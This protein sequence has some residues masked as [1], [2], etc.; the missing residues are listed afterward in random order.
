MK[1]DKVL[2]IGGGI[3]G[4]TTALALQRLGIRAEVFEKSSHLQTHATGFTLWSYAIRHLMD[5]GLSRDTLNSFGSAVQI[6]EIRNK[7]GKLLEEMPV[8]EVSEKLGAP[9]YE[10]LRANL[11]Q[12]IMNSLAPDSLHLKK[13][14]IGVEPAGEKVT[15]IFQ[16]GTQV[17]GDLLI[18]A[19]GIHS[20]V[21]RY[22]A[23][24]FK[25]NYSG[26]SA[27]VAVLPFEHE[28]LAPQHHVEI[29][30]RGA[31]AGVADVGPSQARWYVTHQNP[32]GADAN[33][34][35]TE[36]LE[37]IQGWYPL[38]RDAV[39]ATDA[40]RLVRVEVWDLEPLKT[41][42]KGRV[43][44]LGDAAHATTPFAAMGANM[45]IQDSVKLVDLLQ[46][47]S[48]LDEALQGFQDHRKKRTEEV[49]KKSRSMGKIAHVHSP[50]LAWIR[51]QAF[52]H[53]DPKTIEK[54]TRE[55]AGG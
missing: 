44:L 51:D 33:I 36:V 12:A 38:I 50:I 16:D 45:T 26:Y 19:D 41:W 40:S 46:Y 49:I 4:A 35:K 34:S 21:R 43:V 31:K 22:V 53:M 1:L 2:I 17:T 20:T 10:M 55:M 6:A 52:L 15:A 30:G 5:L 18:G 28:L 23:G 32:V 48:H 47:S 14:C 37:R 25:L 29:W 7:S 42:V 8:G 3:G 11:I 13:E 9:S 24:D 39:Q 54:V 27:V